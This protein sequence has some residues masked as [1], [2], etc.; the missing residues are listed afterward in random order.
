MNSGKIDNQLNLALDVSNQIR[1]GTIDLD[2][3]FNRDFQ[4][5]ELI[6]RYIG[7]LQ[8][9]ADKYEMGYVIL[10]NQYAVITI[11]ED[12]IRPL[13][14]ESQIIFIEMPKRLSYEVMNGIPESCIT[15][16][17]QADLNLTG[18]GVLVAI[19][20]S[21]IDYYHPD[22]RNANGTTRIVEL[23]DQTIQGTPPPGY[24]I[25]TVYTRE[26]INEAIATG[27]RFKALNIVPSTDTSGHGT[28]FGCLKNI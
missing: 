4:T 24:N 22:F 9:L 2:T 20:D 14:L 18:R 7:D 10:M 3:G 28:H 15:Q 12:R 21:G 8:S 1:E 25:G 6:V 19:I 16:V 27:D 11:R 13:A 26:K 5:W 23:W 17:Q